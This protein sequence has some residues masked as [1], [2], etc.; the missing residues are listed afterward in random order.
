MAWHPKREDLLAV[1]VSESGRLLL[2]TLQ[3][4]LQQQTFKAADTSKCLQIVDCRLPGPVTSI[5]F[6]SEGKRLIACSPRS[7][8]L[9]IVTFEDDLKKGISVRLVRQPFSTQMTTLAWSPDNRR[10]LALMTTGG[11]L[12]IYES[13]QWSSKCW[14]AANQKQNGNDSIFSTSTSSVI[15]QTAVWSRPSG[16]ILLYAAKGSSQIYALPFYDKAEAGD[17]GGGPADSS[18]LLLDTADGSHLG[19]EQE[20]LGTAI[21]SIVWDRSSRRL[22]VLFEGMIC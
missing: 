19:P 22:A 15:V 4:D 12:K 7:S 20:P 9:S 16:R 21:Q 3:A 14:R 11:K 2:W 6:D 10:L 8:S 5:V 1:A 18:L 17:V 13:L